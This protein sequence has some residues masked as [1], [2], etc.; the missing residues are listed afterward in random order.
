MRH[1]RLRRKLGVRSEHR[2]AL[3]RN[4][5]RAL[6]L[7][8]RIV[9]TYAQAKEAS[10]FA[11]KLVTLARHTG[12]HARRLLISKTHSDEIAKLLIRQIV[13]QFQNRQGGYTRVLRLGVRPGD[14]A[15]KA[16]LEWTAV[17]DA[18]AR[19]AKKTKEKKPSEKTEEKPSTKEVSKIP[20][21]KKEAAKQEKAEKKDSEK[22]GGFLKNLRKFFKGDEY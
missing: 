21:S 5:V 17:F 2:A 12:L 4:L 13:P 22:K 11:D 6:V 8:K 19:K 7:K 15:Q 14:G 1:R 18:P 9:T 10:A 20:E 16:L 3:L